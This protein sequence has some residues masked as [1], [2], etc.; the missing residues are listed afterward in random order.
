MS[1]EAEVHNLINKN[2][3]KL[4]SDYIFSAQ[5]LFDYDTEELVTTLNV[6]SKQGNRPEKPIRIR[7]TPQGS[8]NDTPREANY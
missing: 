7:H 3:K 6:K 4:D 5:T 2:L 8:V 1:I